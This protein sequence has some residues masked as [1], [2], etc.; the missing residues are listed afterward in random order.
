MRLPPQYPQN[1][2]TYRLQSSLANV[3]G[4]SLD[5]SSFL[6]QILVCGTAVLPQL[7]RFWVF[8]QSE[9]ANKGSYNISIGVMRLRLLDLQGDNNQ[10]RKLQ[11]ADLPQGWEDIE[12]VLQYGGLPYIPEIIWLE[13]INWHHD[14]PLAGHF[15]IDKTQELIARKYY[16]PMLFRDIEAYVKGCN[17]CLAF[18]AVCHKP[19][20]NL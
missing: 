9:I 14:D 17:V 5:I 12:G 8:F 1:T 11:A 13:L 19:Y 20:R 6:Y 10:A 15:G 16:W 2:L 7:R 18:K 3:S 4:L